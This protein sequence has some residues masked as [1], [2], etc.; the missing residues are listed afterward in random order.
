MADVAGKDV[1][2]CFKPNP[3]RIKFCGKNVF[4]CEWT[5]KLCRDAHTCLVD[6]KRFGIFYNEKAGQDALKVLRGKKKDHPVCKATEI[7]FEKTHADIV[8]PATSSNGKPPGSK[9][10]NGPASKRHAFVVS[11]TEDGRSVEYDAKIKDFETARSR[12]FNNAVGEY[13]VHCYLAGKEQ[14]PL[15][16]VTK[17]MGSFPWKWVDALDSVINGQSIVM[18]ADVALL[19]EIEAEKAIR[20][21]TVLKTTEPM[22]NGHAHGHSV[23]VKDASPPAKRLKTQKTRA[24]ARPKPQPAPQTPATS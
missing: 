12:V 19:G 11:E 2:Y 9:S 5:G 10:G 16:V 13:R 18:C 23:P 17:P 15:S 4:I 20:A 8:V 14:I 3:K 7:L 22:A 24:P 21:E 1:D 6:G